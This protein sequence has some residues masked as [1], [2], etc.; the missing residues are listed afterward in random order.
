MSCR[1]ISISEN[2][3][4]LMAYCARVSSPNKD[5]PNIKGLLRYFAKLG[6]CMVF[7]LAI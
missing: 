3:E 2:A 1:L 6:H 7:V 5:N 4:A